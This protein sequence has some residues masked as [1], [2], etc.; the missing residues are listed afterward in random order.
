MPRLHSGA[1]LIAEEWSSAMKEVREPNYND[2]SLS[3]IERAC[4][5]IRDVHG[6]WHP[7][8]SL[9]D[10]SGYLAGIPTDNLW[11]LGEQSE[12]SD[13]TYFYLAWHGPIFIFVA[14]VTDNTPPS[15]PQSPSDTGSPSPSVSQEAVTSTTLKIKNIRLRIPVTKGKS[16]E[17][18]VPPPRGTKRSADQDN[19]DDP[20]SDG[21]SSPRL[22]QRPRLDYVSVMFVHITS[23]CM[24]YTYLS[25]RRCVGHA[26]RQNYHIAYRRRPND[27]QRSAKHVQTQRGIVHHSPHGLNQSMMVWTHVRLLPSPVFIT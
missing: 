21:P 6:D 13:G 12:P 4:C 10:L 26:G 16:P 2:I 9:V 25:F 7:D 11:W 15:P 1:Q 14:I 27:V 20:T 5:T 18:P 23:D 19:L 8:L 22:A 3:D 17:E 24:T